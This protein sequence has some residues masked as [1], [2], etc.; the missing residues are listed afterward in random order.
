MR[1]YARA[2][3]ERAELRRAMGDVAAA[4]AD[5]AKADQVP[6]NWPDP[7]EFMLFVALG[8]LL[9]PINIIPSVAAAILLRRRWLSLSVAVGCGAAQGLIG[10]L[11]DFYD[12]LFSPRGLEALSWVLMLPTGMY[13]AVNL[14]W[15]GLARWLHGLR[16]RH[17]PRPQTSP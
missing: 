16:R 5:E 4:K 7:G 12:A 11:V 14:A 2:Y 3:R 13:A 1:N 9:N 10:P 8:L 6:K 15:W 17:P